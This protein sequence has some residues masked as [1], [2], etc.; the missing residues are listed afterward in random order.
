MMGMKPGYIC[1]AAT[2]SPGANAVALSQAVRDLVAEIADPLPGSIE[3][4]FFYDQAIQIKDSIDDVKQTILIALIL[5]VMVIFLFLGRVSDTM[6]PALVLPVTLF[7][8]FLVMLFAGFSL[9][10]LSLMALTLSIGFLVDDAIVV[11]ENTVRYIQAG[12]EAAGGGHHQHGGDHRDGISTSLALV[13]VFVPLVFMG[14]VVGRNFKEFAL[15]VI[16]AIAV[17]TM[18]ALTLSPMMCARVLKGVRR[19][20]QTSPGAVHRTHLYPGGGALRVDADWFLQHKYLAIL[21]WLACLVGIAYFF[22]ALLPK[23]FMPIG[24]SGTFLRAVH[25]HPGDLDRSDPGLSG[26]DQR[27]CRRPSRAGELLTVTGSNTGSDQSTT[28]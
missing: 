10:N 26:P 1:I 9:D 22:S 5:V 18:M 6:V 25:G 12:K 14:G 28:G 17:S 27:D 4:D 24:D 15:V 21:G 16:I 2:K 11:L 3:V 13:T 20:R 19:R 23:S 8:T 7:G